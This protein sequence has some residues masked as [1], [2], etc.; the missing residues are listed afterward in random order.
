MIQSSLIDKREATLFFYC[1]NLTI[2]SASSYANVIKTSSY[3]ECYTFNVK[4]GGHVVE[5]IWVDQQL[6]TYLNHGN[7]KVHSVYDHA[8]NLSNDLGMITLV[9]Q[10]KPKAPLTCV[11]DLQSFL[12]LQLNQGMPVQRYGHTLRMG[13]LSV[14]FSMATTTSLDQVRGCYPDL[15]SI[16]L[17]HQSL[18][19]WL[20]QHSQQEGAIRLFST[21]HD[22]FSQHLVSILKTYLQTHD[23]QLLPKLI[24]CGIGQTPSGDDVL[25]GMLSLA[26]SCFH[27]GFIQM[28]KHCCEPLLNQTT[29][30]SQMMLRQA[31]EGQF[32]EVHQDLILSLSRPHKVKEKADVCQRIGHT[33]GTDFLVG[34]A[35]YGY[36]HK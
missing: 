15:E 25:V 30:V 33:S 27:L 4:G 13:S 24:G 5:A 21:P 7:L 16:R 32:N 10:D 36:T 2:E 12:N 11:C 1:A 26:W 34:V 19:K 14:D 31:F 18:T 22:V 3:C 9:S 35:V 8:L 23:I 29:D 17:G 28:L 20:I 6:K